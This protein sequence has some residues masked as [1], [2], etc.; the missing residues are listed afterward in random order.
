[1]GAPNPDRVSLRARYGQG[2][3]VAEMARAGWEVIS[4]CERCGLM[5]RVDL[6]LIA[7]VRGPNVS[8]WNRKARCRRLLCHGVV[9]FHA[10]APGMPGHEPLTI[11]PRVRDDRPS[12]V[13]RRL[14]GRRGAGQSEAD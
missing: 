14:A 11:D 12:W 10:K 2:R 5:M 8:L 6:K 7:F 13:E 4:C 1:M 9:T 3:T